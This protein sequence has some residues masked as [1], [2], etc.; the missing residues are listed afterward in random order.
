MEVSGIVQS[1][2]CRAA[3]G[4]PASKS[5]ARIMRSDGC[6]LSGS[7]HFLR[8]LSCRTLG[9]C[10]ILHFAGRISGQQLLDLL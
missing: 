3:A 7:G 8:W 4:Y 5:H 2:P 10:S 6:R 1:H 9:A